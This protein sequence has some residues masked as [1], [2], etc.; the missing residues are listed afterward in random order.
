MIGTILSAASLREHIGPAEFISMPAVINFLSRTPLSVCAMDEFGSFLK[1]INN[2]KASGFEGAISGMLRSAW[3][4]SFKI[5]ATP[6]WAGKQM[7]AICSPA[8]SIFG[9]S[10]PREFYD[11]LEGADVTNGVLNRF[12]IIESQQRPPEQRPVVSPDDIPQSIVAR[13]KAIYGRHAL[14]QLLQSKMMPAYEMLSIDEGAEQIRREMVVQLLADGDANR[15]LEPFLARTA[16]NAI[17]LATIQAIGRDS[18]TVEAGDMIWGRDFALWST[19]RLAEGAGLYIADSETQVTANEIKR[20]LK[21]KGRVRRYE[22]IKALS[23]KYRARDLEDVLKMMIEARVLLEERVPS[24][25][26]GGQPARFYTL[27]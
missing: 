6:E 3:G 14:G 21:G 8:M 17:R 20:H 18:M 4:L 13:L 16:E 22:L 27:A 2:R 1:R 7:E 11:S 25:P 24:G 10:T 15:A 5:M 9:V 12:L 19:N 23:F 26:K